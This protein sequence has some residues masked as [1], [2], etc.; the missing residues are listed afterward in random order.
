M[1]VD[2]CT[3]DPVVVTCVDPVPLV[4]LASTSLVTS[5]S[6]SEFQY[7]EEDAVVS[8]VVI[9]RTPDTVDV[10]RPEA[11]EM[12]IPLTA[13]GLLASVEGGVVDSPLVSTKADLN[14][15]QPAAGSCGTVPDPLTIEEGG[16]QRTD[17]ITELADIDMAAVHVPVVSSEMSAVGPTDPTVSSE[18][19]PSESVV[20]TV[21]RDSESLQPGR[22][23]PT[24]SATSPT[25]EDN[26]QQDPK[27]ARASTEEHN[28]NPPAGSSMLQQL[29]GTTLE[30]DQ[31]LSLPPVKECSEQPPSPSAV[32]SS[33]SGSYNGVG[34]VGLEECIDRP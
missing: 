31:L 10:E 34:E 12:C 2:E 29:Q 21:Q 4:T 27:D 32:C 28:Q 1:E 17:T 5:A 26:Q 7:K 20:R 19:Q 6:H 15:L 33:N 11:V 9:K 30:S 24:A 16:T 14:V 13:E 3:A 18:A 22:E 8:E 23:E 25:P